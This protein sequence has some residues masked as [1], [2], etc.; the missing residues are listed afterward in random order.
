MKDRVPANPG[1]VLITPENGSAAFYA[2]MTRADNPTQEGDPLN[3]NTLLKDATAALFGL[4][5]DAV[6]D[7]V[8]AMLA[9]YTKYFWKKQQLDIS[10]LLGSQTNVVHNYS[11]SGG[12]TVYYS[13]EIEYV[14]RSEAKLK[15]PSSITITSGGA[16]EINANVKG[17]YFYT[18]MHNTL[19]FMPSTAR[20]ENG[21]SVS[22]TIPAQLVTIKS[23]DVGN[24]DFVH[25]VSRDAYPD[26]GIIDGVEY[27]FLGKPLDNAISAAKIETGSYVGTGTYGADNPCS[28]T[29]DFEPKLIIIT[30]STSSGYLAT[31]FFVYGLMNFIGLRS[32]STS[33][34]NATAWY[35]SVS[36]DGN[37]VSF[38]ASSHAMNQFNESGRTNYYVAVG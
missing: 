24:P 36:W 35:G 2:T 6:P 13:S 29:F 8:L 33:G 19:Y 10:V 16:S 18:T 12:M 38:N 27:V 9:P 14:S 28:I 34:G 20:A 37:T 31:G 32:N 21:S 23:T 3:K 11:S 17:K 5:T 26:S 1:R 4:G 15:N 25:S 30:A 7:D 22:L